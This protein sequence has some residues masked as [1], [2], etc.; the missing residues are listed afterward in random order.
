MPS[1]FPGMDPYLENVELWSGVHAGLIAKVQ[2]QLAVLLAP[3]YFVSFEERVFITADDD[4]AFRVV[5][6]DVHLVAGDSARPTSGS[7]ARLGAGGAAIARPLPV[8]ETLSETVREGRLEV[9]DATDQSVVTVIEILSPTNKVSGSRGRASFVRKRRQVY[10]S[11]THWMEIDLIRGGDRTANRAPAAG[12]AYQA[13]VSRHDVRQDGRRCYLWPIPLRE[14]LP[15][16]GVP[17]RDGEPD[18]P[19]NLQAALDLVYARGS[20]DRRLG[21]AAAPPPPP[22]SADDLA[23][24]RDRIAAWRATAAG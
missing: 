9:R 24:C 23:W 7:D 16:V 19:L 15:I 8:V 20:Y 21:Y 5:Y 11:S 4:P 12:T 22:L 3:R 17:L 2:D 1:P 14:P 18:A 10:A 13:F 6:P